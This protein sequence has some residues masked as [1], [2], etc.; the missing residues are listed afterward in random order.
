MTSL[1]SSFKALIAASLLLGGTA[2][3]APASAQDMTAYKDMPAGVYAVDKTHASLTWK[4]SHA[5][6]S[7]YTARFKSFDAEIKF[8]PKDVTKS[9]VTATIDPRTLETDYVATAEKD[10]NKNLVE[11]DKWFNAKQFPKISFKSTRIEK[12]GDNTGKMHGD[13]TFLGVTKPVTLDVTF[14]GAYAVQP[15]SQKPTLGFSATGK[16]KRSDWGMETYVPMIGDEVALQIE[17]EFAQQVA[18]K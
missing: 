2:A 17:G 15:F 12:T 9:T 5:G 13:L 8:D 7:N 14:N 10:F 4:V 1:Q 16:I 3:F 18:A 6:L 11:E